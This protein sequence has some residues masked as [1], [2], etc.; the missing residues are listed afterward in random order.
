MLTAILSNLNYIS[1][2]LA[3]IAAWVFGAVWYMALARPWM[4]AQGW[5]SREDAPRRAG[6]AAAAP[7]VLSFVA[8][9]V[10]AAMLYGIVQHIGDV[11]VER[12]LFSAFMIWIGFVLTTIA[13]NNAYPGRR[14]MLTV[15]D[16]GHWLGVLL[17]MAVVIGLFGA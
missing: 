1:V 10:M 17:V 12:A 3:A 9:I 16:S 15:I 6:P 4:T 2:L 13:V 11:T 7:F 8:E 5:R 14:L